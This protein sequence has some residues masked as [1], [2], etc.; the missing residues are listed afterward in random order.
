MKDVDPRVFTRMLRKDG[1][2]TISHRNFVGK[3]II[4]LKSTALRPLKE[5]K[6]CVGCTFVVQ[7]DFYQ[8]I[9]NIPP[10]EILINSIDIM[11][12]KYYVIIHLIFITNAQIHVQSGAVVAVI[13]W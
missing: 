13:V 1:S 9:L 8:Y 10:N 2:V 11:I 12:D 3:G 5:C 4:I 7:C 6:T